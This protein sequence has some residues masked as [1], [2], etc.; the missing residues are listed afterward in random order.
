MSRIVSPAK[1]RMLQIIL[2][3]CEMLRA[4][5]G[6]ARLPLPLHGIY[7]RPLTR[8]GPSDRVELVVL[9]VAIAMACVGIEIL[10]SGMVL[11]QVVRMAEAAGAK[12]MVHC[13]TEII[14]IGEAIIE[15]LMLLLM[16]WRQKHW[17]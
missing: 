17:R 8:D 12:R 3:R 1:Q 5:H 11:R 9:Q 4:L 2:L 15:R 14:S 10:E 7:V 13:G 16:H 6:R